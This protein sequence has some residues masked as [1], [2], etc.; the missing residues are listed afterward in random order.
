[1]LNCCRLSTPDECS[2]FTEQM[3]ELCAEEF[4]LQFTAT[5]EQTPYFIHVHR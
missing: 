5:V 2:W 3:T 4:D 1:M